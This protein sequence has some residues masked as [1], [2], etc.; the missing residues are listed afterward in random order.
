[1]PSPESP[2][3]N[4]HERQKCLRTSGAFSG[5]K[6]PPPFA[7]RRPRRKKIP[8]KSAAVRISVDCQTQLADAK[9]SKKAAKLSMIVTMMNPL[10]R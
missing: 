5:A 1:V 10:P 9:L 7:R 4:I 2:L 3:T 6:P 8:R